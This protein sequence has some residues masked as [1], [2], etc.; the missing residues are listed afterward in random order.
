MARSYG[1]PVFKLN[2]ILNVVTFLIFTDAL[3][4][5]CNT[6]CNTL[7]FNQLYH[8]ETGSDI[9]KFLISIFKCC[10]THLSLASHKRDIGKQCRPRSDAAF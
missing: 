5:E 7:H 6:P 9:Q 3:Q 4:E 1:I 10:L 8:L 2:R